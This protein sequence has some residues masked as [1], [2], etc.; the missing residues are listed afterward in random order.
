[1]KRCPERSVV[2]TTPRLR[3][4]HPLVGTWE[5]QEN[6][7]YQ[8]SVVYEIKVADGHLWVSGKDEETGKYLTV[9]GVVWDGEALRFTT[10]F[11]PTRHRATHVMRVTRSGRATHDV[12]KQRELWIRRPKPRG[13][14]LAR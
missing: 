14:R 7:V 5:E 2:L 8:T 13:A 9:S 12:G 6:P 10:Y 1:M 11:P 4:N 3:S